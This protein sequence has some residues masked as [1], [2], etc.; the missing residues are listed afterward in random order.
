MVSEQEDEVEKARKSKKTRGGAEK[1][2]NV[3]ERDTQQQGRIC[4]P[5]LPVLYVFQLRTKLSYLQ[6]HTVYSVMR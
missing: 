1:E 3:P 4:A 2:E 5:E 6:E